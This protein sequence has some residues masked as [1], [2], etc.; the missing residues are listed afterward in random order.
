M[1]KTFSM[2]DVGR[3]RQLNQDY[4]FTS[5]KPIGNMPNLFIVADGMG[6]HNAGDFA[7]RYSVETIVQEIKG[8]FEKNPTIIIKKA[9]QAANRMIREKACSDA[10]LFGMGTTIVVATVIGKYLQVANVGDSRLYIVNSEEIR[11]VTRDHSLV[12]EMVRLGGLSR[13]DARLHPDKNIIT[14][15]IG[16]REDIEVDFFTVELKA[17]DCILMCSDGLTNMIEDEEIRTIMNSQ[18]DLVEAA[19]ELIYTANMNGGKDNI[20]V[21]LVRP[22]VEEVEK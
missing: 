4:V 19:Q 11:Q 13:E 10:N 7:S 20:A 6:G 17:G 14:R 12:E 8:S 2:T 15:A 1:L 16:V 9:I 18:R 5:D 21:V 22:F 3:K